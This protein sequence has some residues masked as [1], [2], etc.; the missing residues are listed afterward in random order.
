MH[1]CEWCDVSMIKRKLDQNDLKLATIVVLNTLPK[2]IDF[3]FKRSRVVGAGSASLRVS[4]LL[5]I[6]NEEPLPLSVFIHADDVHQRCRFA[7][8]LSALSFFFVCF[9]FW[10]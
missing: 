5:P 9:C 2:P 10:S 4:R 1:V 8:A 6:H 3:G 7:S